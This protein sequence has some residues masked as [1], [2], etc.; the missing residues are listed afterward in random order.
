MRLDRL[1][2]A[3]PV[4][5]AFSMGLLGLAAV[6]CPGAAFADIRVMCY[7]DGNECDVT[8]DLIKRYEAQNPGAKVILDVVPFK[9]VVEQLPIQ[10]AAGQGPDIARVAEIG[11]LSKNYIDISPYVKDRKYW[12][13][14]FGSTLGWM[15]QNAQDKGIHGFLSQMTMT[16]PFVNKTLFEQA[17]VALPGPKATWEEWVEATRKVAK[18]TQTP[19]AMA[20]DR[21]GHRFAGPAV[22][23]GAKIFDAKGNLALDDGYKTAI[24]KFV[25]W[26][27]DGTILKD[28]WGGS[29]GS[30]YADSIGEFKNGRVVMVLSGSW[31]INR[32]Q[33]EI[34]TN[35]DWVAVPNP[36]GPAAC[37][38]MPG[39]A[40]WVA[41]KT[42]KSPK[43]VGQFLDF[44]AQEPQVAEFASRTSN[45]PAHVGV[46]AKGVDYPNAGPLAKAALT[47]FSRGTSTIAPAAFQL[48][49]YRYN[50]ALMLPTV[51]RVT[52]AIVGEISVDEAVNKIGTDMAEA[53]R[54]AEK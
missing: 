43:E 52:Q 25:G 7:Q 8:A 1:D 41:L 48:Q 2:T 13:T 17:K 42:T 30:S 35:F 24:T 44:M 19:A 40:A 22:S 32:L 34:G 6:A 10:L 26:H 39:G 9:T 27:K 33:K 12:E 28:V 50:R 15:R 49:G 51:S 36:C 47:T 31:Q 20:W 4:K 18:A 29:G 46:A 45:I 38:G 23:Y 21:S 14:N 54:Q 16:G 53:V 37:S 3:R 5:T 11:G